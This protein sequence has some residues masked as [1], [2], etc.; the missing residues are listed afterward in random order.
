MLMFLEKASSLRQVNLVKK[1]YTGDLGHEI[2][3][4]SGLRQ[5]GLS[6]KYNKSVIL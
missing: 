4:S 2:S 6:K 1:L 5:S 3:K